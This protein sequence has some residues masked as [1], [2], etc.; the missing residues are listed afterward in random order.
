MEI[1]CIL[2]VEMC[3]NSASYLGY[4]KARVYLES[5]CSVAFLPDNGTFI[6]TAKD[7]LEFSIIVRV[8]NHPA[9]LNGSIYYIGSTFSYTPTVSWTGSKP[10]TVV[11]KPNVD[12]S[13]PVCFN[14]ILMQF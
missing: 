14:L 2:D 11:N 8:E 13:T 12:Y 6:P 9:V 7:Q 1:T 3:V 4:Y 5:L 10:I